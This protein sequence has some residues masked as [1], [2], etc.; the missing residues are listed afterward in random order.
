MRRSGVMLGGANG[1]S[2][3]NT[4]SRMQSRSH[5]ISACS[6]DFPRHQS[7]ISVW[8]SPFSS[9]SLSRPVSPHCPQIVMPPPPPVHPSAPSACPPTPPPSQPVRGTT[10]CRP[11]LPGTRLRAVPLAHPV[12]PVV[13]PPPSRAGALSMPSPFV[14]SLCPCPLLCL[15]TPTASTPRPPLVDQSPHPPSLLPARLLSSVQRL[16]YLRPRAPFRQW[17]I[18]DLVDDTVSIFRS[19]LAVSWGREDFGKIVQYRPL[20]PLLARSLACF[21]PFLT[22]QLRLVGQYRAKRKGHPWPSRAAALY[23]PGACQTSVG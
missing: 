6:G 22:A 19:F 21:L 23:H 14:C 17:K 15:V 16:L 20:G 11:R 8:M 18:V 10:A 13:G 9:C 1:A 7:H 3:H 4:A 5:L 2:R 12:R